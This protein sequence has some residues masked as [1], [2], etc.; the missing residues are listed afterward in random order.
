MIRSEI[1]NLAGRLGIGK[2]AFNKGAFV[3]LFP[4]YTE[5][6]TGNLS[7]YARGE[8]YHSVAMRKLKVIAEKILDFGA[9]RAEIHV[10][11]GVLDDRDGA[12]RA[13]LG[14]YGKNGMLICEEY[15]SYFFI[16]QIVHDL[17][18]G[19]DSPSEKTCMECGRCIS[20]CPGGALSGDG[21]CLE[22]CLSHISQKKG[23]LSEDEAELIKKS[24][25]CWGCDVC[26][27][28]CPHNIGIGNTAMPE[29]TAQRIT[30]L[31]TD[32]VEGLSNR[33]FKEK[34][35][36]YAFSWRGK[37]TLLRNLKILSS[38]RDENE[39]E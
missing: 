25:M 21:F 33:E 16:G 4:Y 28:V 24:G 36:S 27:S 14:F 37:A 39:E 18:V 2:A 38:V 6:E 34:Y 5:G 26:Q 31:N 3:A 8:D 22:K 1:L 29:F 7:M 13:G 32:D 12:F 15:G 30:S 10:D 17:D 9:S 11:K 23:E 35:G 20:E 19:E